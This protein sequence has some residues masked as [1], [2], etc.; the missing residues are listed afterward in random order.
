M[1]SKFDLTLSYSLSFSSLSSTSTRTSLHTHP[2]QFLQHLHRMCF[3]FV[4]ARFKESLHFIHICEE[5]LILLI[6]S[7]IRGPCGRVEFHVLCCHSPPLSTP[8]LPGER[9]ITHPGMRARKEGLREFVDR[10]GGVHVLKLRHHHFKSILLQPLNGF[11]KRLSFG[12]GNLND[13]NTLL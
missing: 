1:I 3:F 4:P 9:A 2:T 5:Y 7:L 8:L 13:V 10:C 12:T 11:T 6:Q